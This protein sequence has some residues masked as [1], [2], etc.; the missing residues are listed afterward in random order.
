MTRKQIYRTLYNVGQ[1][2]PVSDSADY[3]FKAVAAQGCWS[4]PANGPRRTAQVSSVCL[5]RL[6]PQRVSGASGVIARPGAALEG[7]KICRTVGP[8][9]LSRPQPTGPVA[10]DM[11]AGHDLSRGTSGRMSHQ[12]REVS[13]CLAQSHS[14]SSGAEKELGGVNTVLST[15]LHNLQ[16]V[17]PSPL[18]ENCAT[19]CS[20]LRGALAQDCFSYV[21]VSASEALGACEIDP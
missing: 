17:K 16:L 12:E 9:A 20:K 10:L 19:Y 11:P 8:L 15:L 4:F 5:G 2:R 6:L 3:N 21:A 1:R 7:Q 14:Q 13:C 18:P